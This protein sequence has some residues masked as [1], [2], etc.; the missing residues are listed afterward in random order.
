MKAN[1]YAGRIASNGP[2]KTGWK[3]VNYSLLTNKTRMVCI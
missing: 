2:M 3:L 1:R